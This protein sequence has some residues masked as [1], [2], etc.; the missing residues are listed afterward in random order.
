MSQKTLF[1]IITILALL[2]IALFGSAYFISREKNIPAGEVLLDFLPFGK[3]AE[4]TVRNMPVIPP[5]NTSSEDSEEEVLSPTPEGA[6]VSA[7]EVKKLVAGPIAGATIDTSA[8]N[9]SRVYYVERET[10]NV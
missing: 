10:G 9:T 5:P 7:L 3:G 2:V 4:D 1:I 6:E 8:T